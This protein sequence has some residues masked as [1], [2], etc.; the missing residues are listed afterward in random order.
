MDYMNTPLNTKQIITAAFPLLLLLMGVAFEYTGFDVWWVSHFYDEQSRSW[1]FRG[2]WLFDTVI[3]GWGRYFDMLAAISWLIFFVLTWCLNSFKKYKKI[4]LYV[5]TAS[6]AGPLM[7]GIGKQT[8]HI[9]TPWELK[10]F[11]GTLPYIRIFDPVPN[12]LPIGEAFPAG[13]AAGG[14][15]FFSLYFLLAHL[16][17][18]Y[19]NYSLFFGLGLGLLFGIGQQ[20]RGAHFPSHDLFTMVI[21]WYSALIVYCLFYPNTWKG[22]PI[23]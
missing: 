20:V 1:P 10:I 17:S 19:K 8:T 7:V 15:A 5:L 9:Y 2:H 13:H 22:H 21:C 11:S 12:G 18:P 16:Q 14:Y 6:A 4:M 3:H 23:W